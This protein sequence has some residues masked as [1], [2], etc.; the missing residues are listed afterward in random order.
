MSIEFQQMQKDLQSSLDNYKQFGFEY[1][2][3]LEH[4]EKVIEQQ[5]KLGCLPDKFRAPVGVQFEL[6]YK[7]NLRCKQ[8]YNDSGIQKKPELSTNQWLNITEKL[9]KMGLF[10]CVISGGEPLLHDGLFD[11]MNM[12]DDYQVKVILITNGWLLNADIVSKLSK[13]DFNW[14]QVSIDGAKSKTH[15]SI[16]GKS[17]S[18]ERAIRGAK[19]VADEGLPLVIANVGMRSNLE[20]LGELIDISG[21]L[22]ACQ[23]ITGEGLLIGRGSALAKELPFTKEEREKFY[24]ITN[25]KRKEWGNSTSVSISLP[26]EISS[27]YNFIIPPRV[28]LIR[29]N[30]DVK[31]GCMEPFKVGNVLDS[32]LETLWRRV[33]DAWDH[34]MVKE[35]INHI[36][37]N[38][39]LSTYKRGIPHVVDDINLFETKR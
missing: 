14:L 10:E 34:P 18:W 36:T 7:C 21:Y 11:I 39:S 17:G 32:D 1:D 3:Y 13:Y 22:G 28:M 5:K 8:C 9:C 4:W 31:L 24:T 37:D 12:L 30:G 19:L 26:P 23:I 20:E 35:F 2:K 15:D 6:T 25:E 16:R 27:R 29:P 38:K 33:R